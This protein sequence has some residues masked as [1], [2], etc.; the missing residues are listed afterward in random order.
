MGP[1]TTEA[2]GVYCKTYKACQ[3]GENSEE[4]RCEA[5]RTYYTAIRRAKRECWEAF[6]QQT[7][8]GSIPEQKWCCAS[9]RNTKPNTNGTTPA[10]IDPVTKKV[11]AAT[12][13]EKEALFKEQAFP[14]AS[15]QGPEEAIHKL[16][17]PGPG[18]AHKLATEAAI[19]HALFSPA[20]EKAPGTNLLNFRL[21]GSSG[22][23]IKPV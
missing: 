21:S 14:H 15:E 17:L 2:R 16:D 8:E 11:I 13:S 12:F 18:N 4:E 5:R 7:D 23:S 9:L 22:G 6:L 3:A 20:V 10:L 19:H 1:Q